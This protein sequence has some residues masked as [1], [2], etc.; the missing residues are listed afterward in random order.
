MPSHLEMTALVMMGS[1]GTM[2]VQSRRFGSPLQ[3]KADFAGHAAGEA[4]DLCVE[5]VS[6]RPQLLHIEVVGLFREAL[7]R[8]RPLRI[9]DVDPPS[10]V[11]AKAGRERDDLQLMFAIFGSM[12]TALLMRSMA[13]G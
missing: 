11:A 3:E 8:A 4:D 9:C 1:P 6:E 13:S 12:R 7:E 2:R 10:A 5:L